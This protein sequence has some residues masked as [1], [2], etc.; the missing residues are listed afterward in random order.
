ML[1]NLPTCQSSTTTTPETTATAIHDAQP[2]DIHNSNIC[3]FRYPK[4]LGVL[5]YYYNPRPSNTVV[6]TGKATF[7]TKEG[8]K[9]TAGRYDINY[10][11][12][13]FYFLL[14]IYT[15]YIFFFNEKQ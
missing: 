7:Q 15:K 2:A 13:V 9:T 1:E 12:N 14:Q 3:R 10:H 8:R 5:S 6:I 4:A 11:N